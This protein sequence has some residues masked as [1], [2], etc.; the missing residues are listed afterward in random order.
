[1]HKWSIIYFE[2]KID[3]IFLFNYSMIILEVWTGEV[4]FIY[5]QTPVWTV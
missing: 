4:K 2:S 5:I 1:M 3:M